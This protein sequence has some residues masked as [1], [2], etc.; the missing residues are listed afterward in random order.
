ME[1]WH[2]ATLNVEFGLQLD[3]KQGFPPE[4]LVVSL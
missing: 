1:K 3:S 4:A 2:T